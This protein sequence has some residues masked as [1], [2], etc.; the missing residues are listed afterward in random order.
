MVPHWK[1]HHEAYIPECPGC[2]ELV[3][4]ISETIQRRDDDESRHEEMKQ[5]WGIDPDIIEVNS[6]GEKHYGSR[7]AMEALAK[8][9]EQ[10]IA[11]G[12][13]L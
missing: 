12:E 7:K 10:K 5:R 1:N 9:L 13:E 2:Q 4:Q 3:K 8:S 11:E 6:F